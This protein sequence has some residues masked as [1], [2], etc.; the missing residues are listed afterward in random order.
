MAAPDKRC[1]FCKRPANEC[2]S[3][4]GN[5]DGP[6]ICERC[7]SA[8]SETIEEIQKK[9][10]SKPDE[11]P[12][13]KPRE[14]KAHLDEHVISQEK[15]KQDVAVAI[16]N[17]YK[18]RECIRK[19]MKFDC[20]IKKS[21][22][23]LL[24]PSGTGKTEIARTV[25]KML[26]VPFYNADA[27]KMTQAGYVGDDVE[28]MIQGILQDAGGDTERA[29][30]GIIFLDEVDK[31]ARKSGRGASGYRD[32]TGE[33]VQQA[34]LK[35]VE[36]TKVR[37]PRGSARLI[38]SGGQDVDVVDTENVLFICAGSFA[39]IE[40]VVKQRLN[41]SVHM[42]F[43][44]AARK[45]VDDTQTYLSI[46]EEDILE[47][48]IIPELLGRLPVHTTTL[49]LTEDEMVRILTEPKS[50]IVKQFKAMFQMDGIDLQFDDEALK[51]IGREAK[52]RPT[53]ARALRSIMEKILRPYSYDYPSEQEVTAVRITEDVVSGKG[54]AIVVREGR[55]KPE[56]AVMQG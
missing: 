47:F 4:I 10:G 18:R 46:E 45:D 27:T 49:P 29:E 50:A 26:G 34:L 19:G 31:L 54:E 48:G 40:E 53:G 41:K 1:A 5:P 20:E 17:H 14:I 25:S 39:G 9:A 33:G 32:V 24:G 21:N 37:V 13:L 12:L 36:G 23:L 28:S 8:A 43:G 56:P 6:W 2:K 42:G 11:K 22:I 38:G 51:A 3:L 44:S 30:W 55:K 15:A 16:Y 52:K 7:T 35:M